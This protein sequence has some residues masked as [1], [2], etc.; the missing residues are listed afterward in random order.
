MKCLDTPLLEALLRGRTPSKAWEGILRGGGEVA[1]TEVTMVELALRARSGPRALLGRR[2]AAL[3]KVR[4]ALT[5]L[6]LDAEASR[7]AAGLLLHS[8][9]GGSTRAGGDPTVEPALVAAICL[10]RGVSEL[11]TDRRR[12]FPSPLP[13]LHLVR[14]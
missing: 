7:R 3:E 13:G 2:L 5:V 6:P 1:T 9:R 4:G 11:Y 8:K 10:A 12:P 14:V